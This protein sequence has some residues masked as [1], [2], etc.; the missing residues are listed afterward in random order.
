M[1]IIDIFCGAKKKKK[2]LIQE[3]LLYE[4]IFFLH[5]LRNFYFFFLRIHYRTQQRGFEYVFIFKTD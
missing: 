4:N 1:C 5:D 2:K 3:I